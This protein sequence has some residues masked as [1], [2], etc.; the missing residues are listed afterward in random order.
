MRSR[1]GDFWT[2]WSV[3]HDDQPSIYF[4]EQ[5]ARAANCASLSSGHDCWDDR[6]ISLRVYGLPEEV[7]VI[8]TEPKSIDKQTLMEFC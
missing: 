5:L 3:R 2:G 4:I 7:R 6:G 8:G 1:N